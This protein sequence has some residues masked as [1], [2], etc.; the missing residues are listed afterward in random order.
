[1]STKS[2]GIS[3]KE[4]GIYFTE[5]KSIIG[6]RHCERFTGRYH[7]RIHP[8]IPIPMVEAGMARGLI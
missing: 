3:R 4:P 5:E 6:T 7:D 2:L 1:M 8:V